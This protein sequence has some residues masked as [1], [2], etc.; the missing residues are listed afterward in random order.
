MNKE[1]KNFTSIPDNEEYSNA[2]ADG[3]VE[4]LLD[5]QT[6]DDMSEAIP[7]D[8]S[9]HRGGFYDDDTI[10]DIVDPSLLESGEDSELT[11]DESTLDQL[12][13]EVNTE[14]MESNDS[15]SEAYAMAQDAENVYPMEDKMIL[16][17]AGSYENMEAPMP[18]DG[19]M[20]NDVPNGSIFYDDPYGQ[21]NSPL[22]QPPHKPW[23]KNPKILAGIALGTLV[24]IGGIAGCILLNSGSK[25]ALKSVKP[26]ELGDT[27]ILKK[28]NFL[29][30]S[31]MNEDSIQKTKMQS[32]LMTDTD[33]YTYNGGTGEVRSKDMAYL[34]VGEYT[35]EFKLD[36]ESQKAK[37]KVE[38]TKSPVFIGL[39]DTITVEQNAEDFDI[40]SYFL[41]EDKS[42]VDITVDKNPDLS[43]TGEQTIE[44]TAKDKYGNETKEKITVNV[45]SQNAVKNGQKLT[46]TLDGSVPVSSSTKQK[47][48]NGEMTVQ[49]QELSQELKQAVTVAQ[50]EYNRNSASNQTTYKPSDKSSSHLDNTQT[51]KPVENPD[52]KTEGNKNESSNKNQGNSSQE[53]NT[54]SSENQGNNGGNTGN[55]GGSSGNS[56]NNGNTGTYT[57]PT[58][59]DPNP[60][61]TPP[62]SDTG[63]SGGNQG[64][65]VIDKPI[66]PEP[67]VPACDD[68]IPAGGYDMATGNQIAQQYVMSHLDTVWGYSLA[69]YSTECGTTYYMIEYKYL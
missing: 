63:T 56:G 65:A 3:F 34:D 6:Q 55:N 30:D 67:D 7:T 10:D 45:I 5:D 20:P 39:M 12:I 2:E 11:A 33:K 66:T 4:S 43:K 29:D 41:A 32:K 46:E 37:L 16:S 49:T 42:K 22:P 51:N 36:K 13:E 8:E 40:L 14:Y 38:D 47:V 59:V 44:L 18:E 50:Q 69:P 48:E 21:S 61:Y 64:G 60:G 53:N 19:G 62:Q 28:E 17:D 9:G 68:T 24:V 57:P 25:I 27:V 15:G 23:Y 35:V 26:V 54:G 58:P 1:N 52:K 31:K